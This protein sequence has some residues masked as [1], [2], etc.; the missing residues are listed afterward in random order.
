DY[1]GSG[2]LHRTGFLSGPAVLAPPERQN[3]RDG[4]SS[5]QC[6]K[7]GKLL[8]AIPAKYKKNEIVAEYQEVNK[9]LKEQYSRTRQ[10]M[11]QAMEDRTS[12]EIWEFLEL[13]K[14]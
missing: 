1:H 6:Q 11:E 7:G 9:K 13:A 10:M 3:R 5:L 2:R 14:N 8:K 12:F 4:K